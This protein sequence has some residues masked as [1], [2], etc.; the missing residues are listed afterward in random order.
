M[1]LPLLGD[2]SKP[3]LKV[4]VMLDKEL[5]FEGEVPRARVVA[6]VQQSK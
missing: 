1:S 4:E 6:L 3:H 2:L 5:R